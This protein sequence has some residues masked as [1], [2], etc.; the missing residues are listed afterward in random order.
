MIIIIRRSMVYVAHSG[1]DC[2]SLVRVRANLHV[3][4]CFSPVGDAFRSRCRRFPGLINCTRI[5]L[6]RPWPRD[7]LV[8]VS[9][10]FLEDMELGDEEV[11][12]LVGRDYHCEAR[13]TIAR[14]SKQHG[15]AK[16]SVIHRDSPTARNC[17][18]IASFKH[19]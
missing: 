2:I 16:T 3:V 11:R 4:L 13:A 7:A 14:H 15:L 6:F 1:N 12:V 9:Y 5:D 10:W 17:R 18:T 19:P 8:K